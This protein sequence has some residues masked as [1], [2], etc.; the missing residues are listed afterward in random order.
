MSASVHVEWGEHGAALTGHDVVIIV[1]VLS[2]STGVDVAVSRGA[3][4]YPFP[5]RGLAVAD[6]A[7]ASL[8]ARCAGPRRQGGLS[9]SPLSLSVLAPGE[10]VLLPSPNGSTLSLL[11]DLP[12][13]LCGSLR[14]AGAVA[15][16]AA[17]SGDRILIVPA[18]ERWPDGRLRPAVEDQIGAGAI[19]AALALSATPEAEGARAVFLAA[20]ASLASM[21]D[22][23]LSGQ[24]LIE[25]GFP[26][27]VVCAAQ[28]DVSAVA[29]ILVREDRAYGDLGIALPDDIARR[30]VVRYE[31]TR[32]T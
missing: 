18:G 22:A 29:P 7:A 12:A 24:E 11:P 6:A 19:V 4:V 1:D 5:L 2:F 21:L 30:P 25:M 10:S 27:D 31:A 17:R 28:F 26:Q 32:P 16:A 15:R 23:C 13:V 14:N 8:G 3:I 20:Q 9:L